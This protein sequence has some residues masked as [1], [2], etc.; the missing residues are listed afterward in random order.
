[1]SSETT[2]PQAP[3]SPKLITY[4]YEFWEYVSSIE[5]WPE[6]Y[7]AHNKKD[8]MSLSRR[9][10]MLS[11]QEKYRDPKYI[12]ESIWDWWRIASTYITSPETC[13]LASI[14]VA[15]QSKPP[16]LADHPR[17]PN[18]VNYVENQIRK[19]EEAKRKAAA[20]QV[21]T[22]E[23]PIA[24][25]P[26]KPK[27]AA[28]KKA[29]K[30]RATSEAGDDPPPTKKP[31]A[32]VPG[33]NKAG[34]VTTALNT[35]VQVPKEETAASMSG[36]HE[37]KPKVSSLVEQLGGG[38]RSVNDLPTG[39]VRHDLL[40]FQR[41]QRDH[42][43]KVNEALAK[44]ETMLDY[45]T[46]EREER[47]KSQN[48]FQ[49]YVRHANM[50]TETHESHFTSIFSRLGRLE[51]RDNV[52]TRMFAELT[53]I[54]QHLKSPNRTDPFD[55][56]LIV[57]AFDSTFPA[58]GAS[59]ALAHPGPSQG[60]ISGAS[61][62][63]QSSTSIA[64]NTFT[65]SSGTTRP[66]QASQNPPIPAPSIFGTFS[67]STAVSHPSTGVP[68]PPQASHSTTS[69]RAPLGRDSFSNSP[70][71]SPIFNT[72]T[73]PPN[74]NASNTFTNPDSGVS[75]THPYSVQ[76]SMDTM[77]ATSRSNDSVHQLPPLPEFKDECN[78]TPDTQ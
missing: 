56:S 55:D 15:A 35:D 20:A 4:L 5:R 48:Q 30:K 24:P 13:P 41:Q 27:K 60:H 72:Y 21:K 76:G 77:S 6:A 44:Y 10:F 28:A 23:A 43:P 69:D 68:P 54:K 26:A 67:D 40:A 3:P 31:K 53:A 33:T 16:L 78:D 57:N 7:H 34:T 47:L 70:S 45:C 50:T 65:N 12:G 42:I 1:M 19:E 8:V 2:T 11:T 29:S 73:N 38:F 25:P 62:A 61:Q 71:M 74:P 39:D 63:S 52:L 75:T 37:S 32:S 59:L 51:D 49:A 18:L 14:A 46:R 9:I 64:Y 66:P 58:M 17:P 22:A 36:A